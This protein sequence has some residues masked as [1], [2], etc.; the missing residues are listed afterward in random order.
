ML[1]ISYRC[2]SELAPLHLSS[3]ISVFIN[4]ELFNF[5]YSVLT[6]S[7]IRYS[8]TSSS[9]PNSPLDCLPLKWDLDRTPTLAD[10]GLTDAVFQRI[11]AAKI[12]HL[13]AP[14]RK[15]VCSSKET[16]SM[17]VG[18]FVIFHKNYLVIITM[19]CGS[20]ISSTAEEVS[21][22]SSLIRGGLELGRASSH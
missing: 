6:W 18:T 4:W 7:T 20:G 22:I 9:R 13:P 10:F 17:F 21:S 16:V 2:I 14:E 19:R 15:T 11:E 8:S 3:S 12:S 1:I 5:V